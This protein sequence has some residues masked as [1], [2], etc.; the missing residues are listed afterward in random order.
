MNIAEGIRSV[1]LTLDPIPIKNPDQITLAK[2]VS[3]CP[4][5]RYPVAGQQLHGLVF[6]QHTVRL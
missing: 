6:S 5:A 4:S 2:S 3:C 1:G